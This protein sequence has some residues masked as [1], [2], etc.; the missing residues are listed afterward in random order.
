[1]SAVAPVTAVAA[2]MDL[3]AAAMSQCA[4][5]MSESSNAVKDFDA[6]FTTPIVPSNKSG[7]GNAATAITIAGQIR[8]MTIMTSITN[9]LKN[10]I[11]KISLIVSPY[12]W[13]SFTVGFTLP[14]R[15]CHVV[16]YK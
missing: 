7:A 5:R 8:N 2:S 14:I 13:V 4:E 10:I 9:N 1:M 15:T 12:D 16:F 11:N 6:S 3:T